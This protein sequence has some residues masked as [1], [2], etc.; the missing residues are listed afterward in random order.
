MR[1]LLLACLALS[2]AAP[3]AAPAAAGTP[4]GP[5]AVIE[6]LDKACPVYTRDG[7][8]NGMIA[9]AQ[10]VGFKDFFGTYV[11]RA[12]GVDV[13]IIGAT[14]DV[15]GTRNCTVALD[16]PAAVSGPLPAAIDAWARA[17]GFKA[18]GKPA[19]KT[20]DSGPYT[21]S[22]WTRKGGELAMNVFPAK[23]NGRVNVVVILT[24]G[25]R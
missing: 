22:R 15:A 6:A 16:G 25:V 5:D 21:A 10:G 3:A 20:G 11:R 14:G 19:Q 8:Y 9:A 17:Q 12:A 7:D 23:A 2:L 1:R 24:G 4:V 13:F 18:A